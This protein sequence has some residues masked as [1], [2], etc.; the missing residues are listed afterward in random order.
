MLTNER[1]ELDSKNTARIK[2]LKQ[3]VAERD[4]T[5]QLQSIQ[6]AKA[7][8]ENAATK[9]VER[10]ELQLKESYQSLNKLPAEWKQLHDDVAWLR[11]SSLISSAVCPSSESI[12]RI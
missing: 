5:I 12:F 4:R 8:S 11:R 2:Q 10:L 6:T 3:Q 1:L 7:L 9:G